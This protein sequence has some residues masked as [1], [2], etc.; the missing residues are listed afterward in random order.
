MKKTQVVIGYDDSAPADLAL[1]RGIEIA[2]RDPE[3]VVLHVVRVIDRHQS[4]LRADAVHEDMM[5]RLK[6]R[7]E[8]RRPGVD[9]EI[10][11]HVRIGTPST[12]LLNVAENIS[13]DLIILGS[14]DR[15]PVGRFLRGSV[16][17]AV[18]HGARCPMLIARPKSYAPVDLEKIV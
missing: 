14:R 17:D 2:C 1:E 5:E 18:M 9:V 3:N 4:Y 7:F 15:G 8:A 6:G 11:A 10:F 16:C 12:E 13:A